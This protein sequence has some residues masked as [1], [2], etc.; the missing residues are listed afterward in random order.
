MDGFF[1]LLFAAR[2]I[3]RTPK[4]RSP[5]V[6]AELM[7]GESR[8]LSDN[9]ELAIALIRMVGAGLVDPLFAYQVL[10]LERAGA[11]WFEAT[12][13]SIAIS[14][15][16]LESRTGATIAA[17]MGIRQV[18]IRHSGA[19]SLATFEH[20]GP[21][22]HLFA[23]GELP[24]VFFGGAP[25]PSLSESSTL[26]ERLELADRELWPNLRRSGF[27]FLQD[28]SDWRSFSALVRCAFLAFGIE[29]GSLTYQKHGKRLELKSL[30][31]PPEIRV[32]IIRLATT[33]FRRYRIQAFPPRPDVIPIELERFR[34]SEHQIP[35]LSVTLEATAREKLAASL[36]VTRWLEAGGVTQ[37]NIEHFLDPG[38]GSIRGAW[39]MV[40]F[41][42]RHR[43]ASTSLDTP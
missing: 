18:T 29:Q 9:I 27:S 6:R 38:A 26:M 20:A 37:T 25:R 14:P 35:V 5:L 11:N 19:F 34:L 32:R 43:W 23:K 22:F 24:L 7:N 4:E 17:A 21:E 28:P 40:D 3:G 31:C 33:A 30:G 12:Y 2:R 10:S 1:E 42:E 8:L 16:S 36:A 41:V 13:P 15:T 39:K